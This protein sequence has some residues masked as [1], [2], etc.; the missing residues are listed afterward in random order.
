MFKFQ[1]LSLPHF[2]HHGNMVEFRRRC[3]GKETMRN[4]A[5]HL[6][7]LHMLCYIVTSFKRYLLNSLKMTVVFPF[8]P[9]VPQTLDVI[10]TGILED[11]V[12]FSYL[13][14]FLIR[15]TLEM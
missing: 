10:R 3:K 13:V 1:R 5:D 7:Q 12:Q 14:A 9:Y 4:I 8:L 2:D 15:Y 6:Q 11:F